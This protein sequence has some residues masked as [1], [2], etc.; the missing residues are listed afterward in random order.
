MPDENRVL[1]IGREHEPRPVTEIWASIVTEKNG[2]EGLAAHEMD[3]PAG[4]YMMPLVGA[5]QERIRSLDP[6]ALTVARITGL[7]VTLRR[8][9]LADGA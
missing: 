2:G 7:P 3:T 9:G 4:R 8:F 1:R 6:Y 5:D